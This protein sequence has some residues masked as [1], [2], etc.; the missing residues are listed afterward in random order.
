MSLQKIYSKAVR[1]ELS[2][3]PVWEPG[4]PV[5]LGDYGMLQDGVFQRLGNYVDFL[6]TEALSVDHSKPSSL[7]FVSVGTNVNYFGVNGAP[8]ESL[9][10]LIGATAEIRIEFGSENSLYVKSASTAS[11]EIGN[12]NA[13]CTK[14]RA[15]KGWD[16]SWVV[17]SSIRKAT[18]LA[19]VLGASKSSKVSLKGSIDA[20]KAFDTGQIASE[21]GL[22]V[23]GEAAYK[24]LGATGPLLLNLIRMRRILGGITKAASP[25]T[26]AIKPYEDVDPALD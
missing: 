14:L 23:S 13:I 3:H 11:E 17:V 19:M 16:F 9:G 7:E 15:C 18:N 10:A 24:C 21:S 1:R 12:L 6:P 25:G 4:S 5:A 26:L 20:L 22:V 8:S 2:R